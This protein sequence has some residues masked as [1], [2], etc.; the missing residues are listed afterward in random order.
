MNS[1]Q[2]AID[3]YFGTYI[4]DAIEYFEENVFVSV[5]SNRHDHKHDK[6]MNMFVVDE[7]LIEK[8]DLKIGDE[9][10]RNEINKL[11]E[12][13]LIYEAYQKMVMRISKRA[14]TSFEIEAELRKQFDLN[15]ESIVEVIEM[16]SKRNFL[17]DDA[18]LVEKVAYYRSLNYGNYRIES[19][20]LDKGFDVK[21]IVDYLAEEPIEESFKRAHKRAERFMAT[22]KEGSL[23]QKESKLNDHL[24]RLGYE[25]TIVDAIVLEFV[26]EYTEES[27]LQDLLVTLMKIFEKNSKKYDFYEAKNRSIRTCLSKGYTYDMIIEAFNILGLEA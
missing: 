14:Y 27:E 23:K 16:L 11:E 6:S 26:A 20:L 3:S 7:Y 9:L 1:Y 17:N 2:G 5:V 8:N 19:N 12:E 22:L 24:T 10:S 13:Q 21:T 25:P 4:I 15:E 18:Y